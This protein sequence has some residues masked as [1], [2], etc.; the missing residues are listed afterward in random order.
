MSEVFTVFYCWQSD[1]PTN[2]GKRLI[3]DALDQAASNLSADPAFPFRVQVQS[4]TQNEPGLC[5]I[6]DTIL[7]RLREADAI[8]SDLSYVASSAREQRPKRCANPNVLFELGYAF[9]AIGPERLICV[10]NEA[11]GSASD[12]IF[13]LAHRRHPIRYTS[14]NDKASRAQTVESLARELEQ[15][16]RGVA[17]YGLTGGYGGDDVI[18][19]ERQLS[20][21]KSFRQQR[22]QSSR[23]GRP[24]VSATFRPKVF[25]KK[26]WPDAPTLEH[27][28]RTRGVRAGHYTYPWDRRGNAAMN[29][30][31][32][33]ETYGDAWS[34]TYAGQFWT[35]LNV[36]A[37]GDWEIHE[38]DAQLVPEPLESRVVHSGEWIAARPA[39]AE[40]AA[41]FAFMASLCDEFGDGELVQWTAD[42]TNLRSRWLRF[43]YSERGPCLAPSIERSGELSVADFRA[44]WRDACVEFTKDI[45]DAFSRDGRAISREQLLEYLDPSNAG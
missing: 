16:I 15:A 26:R 13:D 45:C 37:H 34:L 41:A 17:H 23:S 29:W 39:L 3:R 12:Q 19:H 44:S 32:Y 42:A 5:D 8:V 7:R 4:D 18:M 25:R 33:N 35:E 40:M 6:P 14:P 21:I 28:V 22:Q 38:T 31:L 11:Q 2:H 43:E 30:G 20:Q 24:T 1:T 27:V 10:M 36:G 9:K